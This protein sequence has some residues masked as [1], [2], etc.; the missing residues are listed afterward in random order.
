V[1][2]EG[3]VLR[4]GENQDYVI[5]YDR[6]ELRFMNRRRI[7]ADSEIAVDFQVNGSGYRRQT[8]DARHDGKLGR[9]E[10]HGL[11]FS[12]GDDREAPYAGPYKPDEIAV[13]EA[14]GDQPVIAPGIHAV[15]PG[16]GLYRYDAFDSTIVRYDPVTGDLEV[17]FFEAGVGQ[18]AYDDS[19]DALSGRRIFVHRGPGNASRSPLVCAGDQHRLAPA[20]LGVFW[21]G[22]VSR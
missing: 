11:L 6:G 2:L 5:D 1:Y 16:R 19:L 14:A 21:R 15:E 20:Q 10:L 22:C 13:L 7:T 4:R 18:G 3:R 17:E 9:F 12:E 8:Y